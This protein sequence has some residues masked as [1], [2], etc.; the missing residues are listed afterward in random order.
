MVAYL[1]L[2][3]ALRKGRHKV[4][5]KGQEISAPH[6]AQR[7]VGLHKERHRQGVL[8]GRRISA[9]HGVQREFMEM[10]SVYATPEA[11]TLLDDARLQSL[12]QETGNL[13]RR[14]RYILLLSCLLTLTLLLLYARRTKS[15]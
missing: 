9:P 8:Q 12:A 4:A 5:L 13:K 6:G 15:A 14:T 1:I 3:A 11:V 10:L 7:N 2:T